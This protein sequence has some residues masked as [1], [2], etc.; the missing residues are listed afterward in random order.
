[1]RRIGK[2]L[3]RGLLL[4]GIVILAVGIVDAIRPI[5]T[6]TPIPDEE[7]GAGSSAVEPAYSGLLREFPALEQASTD[8]V[9]LGH[10]LFF[11]PILSVNND[12]SCATCHHPDAGFGDD[13]AISKT[14][15]G[16]SLERNS[17]T[18]WNVGYNQHLFW[19]G[20]TAVLE[21]QADEALTHSAEM[22]AN[23]DALVAELADIDAYNDLFQA[24]YGSGVS[25]DGVLTALA[26]FQKSL[27][28]NN[29]P[30][31]QY[32]AGNFNALTP[33]Q[34]R[35]LALFRSGATRCFECHTAPTFQSNNFRVV[36]VDS[37]DPGRAGVVDDG[38]FG[39][40]KVPTLR[41]IAL[42]APYM[43][44]G[45]LA[46]LEEVVDFYADGGGHAHGFENVDVFVQ[47]FE[48]DEQE[49]ADLV[50]FLHA[51][52]D[53]SAKPDVP[54]V[55][56]SGMQTVKPFNSMARSISAEY[57]VG[58]SGQPNNRQPTTLTVEPGQLIQPIIDSAVPGD[59]IEIEYGIY[60][61]TISI[62][63][64]DITLRGIPNGD[65]DYPIF[66]GQG[67]LADAIV[68]SGN[69]FTVSHIH[70]RNYTDN[71]ILVE[72][73]NN[74][75]FHDLITEDTGIY[76][77][78]PVKSTGVLVERVIASGVHDAAIYAG[79]CE[80]VIVRDSEVFDSVIGIEI[81]NTIN[82]DVYN[83]YAHDNSLGIF[84]TVLP[85]LT[86]K[87]SRGG[88]VYN[89][90]VENNNRENTGPEGSAV[91]LVPP[92]TGIL[93]LGSDDIEVYEN[94]ITGNKTTG[95]A[96]FNLT[97]AFDQNEIDVGPNPDNNYFHDNEYDNNGYDPD[98]FVK[99]MGIPTGDILWDGSGWDNRF[100]EPNSAGNFPPYLPG[101]DAPTPTT[102]I[103]W[104]LL[105][106]LIGLVS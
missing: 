63:I 94:R 11:D 29:A 14:A 67:Q 102:K 48:F 22:G 69:N 66:D 45:S 71:G 80:D 13:M 78:Y 75:H 49:K 82:G 73:V 40:F 42:T 3:L 43:H 70:A 62:D 15:D 61:Q 83:N 12:M 55:A 103:Y 87:V 44:D 99:S 74:V 97:V 86:S 10:Q 58:G 91:A 76:G 19:D 32:A 17:P 105:N 90:I 57:N 60:N 81:E 26:A 35:G 36:G 18:L 2:W 88:K 106:R 5:S 64:S 54:A 53:E 89:N 41:N 39:A 21:I 38:L 37:D 28:T 98:A 33:Q 79:Q 84:Y 65:G 101:S 8:M 56:L 92:G 16:R 4:V 72:G 31:D 34:R 20:R 1:M 96:V 100:D 9:D 25:Y 47:G 77:V 30:F 52:T 7:S 51:L 6:D 24:A 93:L 46:T 23:P 59:T 50:A 68:A 95:S 85:Q 104:R 27:V